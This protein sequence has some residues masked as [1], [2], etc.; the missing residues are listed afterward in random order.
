MFG[1]LVAWIIF[2]WH[3][4]S[5]YTVAIQCTQK[6]ANRI[7]KCVCHRLNISMKKSNELEIQKNN[8][9][10]IAQI[11]WWSDRKY[12]LNA[13]YNSYNYLQKY[14]PDSSHLILSYQWFTNALTLL[15]A[16]KSDGLNI[17]PEFF[18]G[19]SIPTGRGEADSS[20]TSPR[21]FFFLRL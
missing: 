10:F 8:E 14:F 9:I 2:A 7:V 16:L 5:F 11:S 18:S 15:R 3:L 4:G 12:N 1:F 17:R 19:L 21:C 6:R 20:K 13:L